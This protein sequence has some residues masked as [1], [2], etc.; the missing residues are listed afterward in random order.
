MLMALGMVK[1][2]ESNLR[3]PEC[4][5][6]EMSKR[7]EHVPPRDSRNAR[8]RQIEQKQDEGRQARISN[9]QGATGTRSE[10]SRGLMSLADKARSVN[11]WAKKDFE[12][13]TVH[14]WEESGEEA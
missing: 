3:F 7:L 12:M 9:S 8:T 1:P 11:P 5:D 14:D 6:I 2:R 13:G 10:R 4:H